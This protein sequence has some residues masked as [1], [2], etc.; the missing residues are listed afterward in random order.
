MVNPGKNNFLGREQKASVCPLP[1]GTI[2]HLQAEVKKQADLIANLQSAALANS[3]AH[4]NLVKHF[5]QLTTQVGL[6]TKSQQ[7]LQD[8]SGVGR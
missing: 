8:L 1:A 3:R 4:N 6:N 2:F 7:L 5:Q